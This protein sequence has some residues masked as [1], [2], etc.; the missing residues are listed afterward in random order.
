M[1]LLRHYLQDFSSLFFPSFC[2]GCGTLLHKGETGICLRCCSRLPR[3]HLHDVRGNRIERLFWGRI[4]V[5]MATAFLFMP[6]RGITHHLIH[7][8]KYKG[9]KQIGDLLGQL[10][11]EDLRR[12]QQMSDFDLILPVPLHPRK[13]YER[14][15]NQC[16]AIGSGL[17]K[18]TGIPF[19]ADHLI[20]G[21]FSG[22]QTRKSRI[23][24]WQN[25][26]SIFR[27]NDAADLTGLHILLIDDVITTGSTLEA[28]CIALKEAADLQISIA[29]L[30]L[31]VR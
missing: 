30:A 7:E 13:L 16:D 12:S 27:I 18:S 28:C 22:S 15:Y 17:M 21:T 1:P 20:R 4:E 29:A 10:F 14:G 3:T 2:G 8:L 31:P 19:S 26:D 6:R 5:E 24:R 23:E 9:N 11:G 25:T